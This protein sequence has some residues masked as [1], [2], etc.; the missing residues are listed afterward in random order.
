MTYFPWSQDYSVGIRLIDNDHKDLV[1]LVNSLHDQIAESDSQAQITKTLSF[2]ARYVREHFAREEALMADYGYPDLAAHRASHHKMTAKIHAA[3]QIFAS[4]PER[5]DPQ[6]LL[7]FLREWLVH[8]IVCADMKYV[9]YLHGEAGDASAT[10][11][12]PQVQPNGSAQPV[13]TVTVTVEVPADKVEL[14]R[15][16]ALLVGVGDEIAAEIEAL[17]ESA[18]VMTLDE[19]EKLIAPL[20]R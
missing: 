19:A 2:L 12:A 18:A 1:D 17:A 7:L 9:P 8:H 16:C 13:E 3:Q 6:K 5:L 15:R 14:I 10:P 11:S 4:E 20:L